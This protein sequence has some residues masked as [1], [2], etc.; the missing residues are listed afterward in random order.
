MSWK[1]F[2][3]YKNTKFQLQH[4]CY[5]IQLIHY[6]HNNEVDTEMVNV[7]S[8]CLLYQY[9]TI[10]SFIWPPL[11]MTCQKHENRLQNTFYEDAYEIP[12][13][14]SEAEHLKTY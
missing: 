4:L 14:T 13:M 1:K 5:E 11:F 7:L 9:V 3:A 2:T 12:F 10:P 6:E 8:C